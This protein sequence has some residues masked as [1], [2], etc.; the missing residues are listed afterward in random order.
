MKVIPI[1]TEDLNPKAK[2]M[3]DSLGRLDLMGQILYT[4]YQIV[5]EDKMATPACQEILLPPFTRTLRNVYQNTQVTQMIL[6]NAKFLNGIR[7]IE[8]A[9]I[10]L[11]PDNIELVKGT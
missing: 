9:N 3:K 11:Q 10:L 8:E 4:G 5:I 7:Q 6:T 1:Y 2:F